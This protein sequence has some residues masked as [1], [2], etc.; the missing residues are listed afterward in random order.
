MLKFLRS[1]LGGSREVDS[2]PRD[3]IASRDAA[4]VATASVM[5][6]SG[7]LK[8]TA[9]SWEID[10]ACR[11][12]D[13]FWAHVHS[14]S[15]FAQNVASQPELKAWLDCKSPDAEPKA[16]IRLALMLSEN[17]ESILN[18]PGISIFLDGRWTEGPGPSQQSD[19]GLALLARALHVPIKL[20]FTKT[21]GAPP[22]MNE[23][24][25]ES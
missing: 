19:R 4:P 13:A 2:R 18:Q 20:Y 21:P 22:W 7:G 9:G 5:G 23:Y 14:D 1:W 15:A 16:F 12:S 3:A 25:P 6:Q 10:E 17:G 24:K 11:D 8:A